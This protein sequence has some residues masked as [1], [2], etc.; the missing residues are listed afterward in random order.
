M[1]LSFLLRWDLV[2]HRRVKGGYFSV[3]MPG[4]CIGLALANLAV[5]LMQLGQPVRRV[6]L[7]AGWRGGSGAA[8]VCYVYL[9]VVPCPRRSCTWCLAR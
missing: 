6:V 9:F 5:I 1:L 7:G 3:A 4:Y 8:H 2:N